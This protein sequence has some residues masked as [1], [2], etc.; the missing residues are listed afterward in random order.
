MAPLLKKAGNDFVIVANEDELFRLALKEIGNEYAVVLPLE[1]K[2]HG[3]KQTSLQGI[4]LIKKIRNE[5]KLRLPI[6]VWSV[7]KRD[8][9][10]NEK[11]K[12]NKKTEILTSS[13]IYF[14]EPPFDFKKLLKL[15]T[16]SEN[17]LED[18]N[19]TFYNPK[20]RASEIVH[21]L[22]NKLG[23][24]AKEAPQKDLFHDLKK[25][26]ES[27]LKPIEDLVLPTNKMKY[28]S[29]K[30]ELLENLASD[31][32][33]HFSQ[34]R[35]DSVKPYENA[36][37]IIDQYSDL[38][39]S[40]L[41]KELSDDGKA[42]AIQ[43]NW[44]VLYVDD[45]KFCREDV[46]EKFQKRNVGCVVAESCD[47]ALEILAKDEKG[48]IAVVVSDIRLLDKDGDW[49]DLQGYDLLNEI[50]EKHH[51][52]LSYF[53]LT[54]KRGTII[55]SIK[56]KAPFAIQWFS[57]S[58]VITSDQGF[59]IFNQ[60]IKELGGDVWFWKKSQPRMR[61]WTSPDS[62]RFTFPLSHYYRRHVERSDYLMAKK[63]IDNLALRYVE[64]VLGKKIN[65]EVEFLVTMK[66]PTINDKMIEKFRL[67]L[68]LGRRIIYALLSG[69]M[70]E[71]AI[72]QAMRPGN[73]FKKSDKDMLF[74]TTMAVSFKNDLPS[75]KDIIEGNLM[76]CNLLEEEIDFLIENFK[77]N[78]A[79]HELK[80]NTE[81]LQI[82]EDVIYDLSVKIERLKFAIPKEVEFF[83][84]KF[85]NNK[86][87]SAL[88][89]DKAL[90]AISKLAEMRAI[91]SELLK[92]LNK[93]L[94]NLHSPKIIALFEKYF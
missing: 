4:D 71:E 48:K 10:R 87:I 85:D 19:N 74:A 21:H 39:Y 25:M 53:V 37:A 84:E 28:I 30:N 70:N 43:T 68:L 31:I 32:E 91:K 59:N 86:L 3:Q 14:L 79:I 93:K 22:K 89:I 73:K 44:N 46:L 27:D 88:E 52:P 24:V 42:D 78:P 77:L 72:F 61:A 51:S 35:K 23:D 20:G 80:V 54:S 56:R 6:I 2:A 26:I 58:D 55:D 82:V 94:E 5:K 69:G 11:N 15:R 76:G 67:N 63:E 17:A 12:L 1:Y 16:L 47:E 60:R 7:L 34:Q 38:V 92:G 90:K 41:P 13:G 75:E 45:T 66:D 29:V 40:L 83:M 9:Y 57:K 36:S 50:F 65:P 8:F 64:N 62:F 18:I 33:I 49:Q 81:D